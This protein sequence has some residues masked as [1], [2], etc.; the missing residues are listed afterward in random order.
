VKKLVV[1]SVLA[2]G[3]IANSNQEAHA[4]T[5]FSFDVGL[6]IKY[7]AAGN[8]LLWGLWQNGPYPGCCGPDCCAPTCGSLNG[9]GAPYL[10]YAPSFPVYGGYYASA[11]G[12][13]ASTATVPAY[14][15]APA[16]SGPVQAT[17]YPNQGGYAPA[18]GYYN[19]P[20]SNGG[21]GYGQ[22]PSYWY[23]K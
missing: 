20:V 16:P 19:Y 8:N 3:L 14:Q 5:K 12:S 23:G 15:P 11:P 2:M 13:N 17:Y 22:V 7:E 18:Y 6:S 9:F 21:Y 4:W 10:P 1:A